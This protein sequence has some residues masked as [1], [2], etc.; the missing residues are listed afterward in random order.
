MRIKLLLASGLILAAGLSA[1]SQSKP[2][3]GKKT[4][5]DMVAGPLLRMNLLER[6]EGPFVGA[7]RDPF[8][9]GAMAEPQVDLPHFGLR[10]GTQPGLAAPGLK[11]EAA[12]AEEAPPPVNIRYVGFIQGKEKLLALVL[13]NGLAVAVAPGES[14][15]DIWKVTRISAAEI[16][17][18]GPEGPALKFAL[19]GERK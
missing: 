19:E 12:A 7:K 6:K 1:F 14:L 9:P 3:R 11:P 15:G 2:A 13:F 5:P 10:S 17:I 4:D 8:I 18:Q 16:E